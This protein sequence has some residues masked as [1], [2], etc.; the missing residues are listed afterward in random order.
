QIAMHWVGPDVFRRYS[1][2][3]SIV[4]PRFGPAQRRM[5]SAAMI[6]IHQNCPHP[7][8]ALE[9]LDFCYRRFIE[10]NA[11]YPFGV[12]EEDRQVLRPL[13][14]IHR[15]LRE[16]LEGAS[17]PLQEGVPQRT[18][19]IENEI[20]D[21]FRLFI[22]RKQRVDRLNVHWDRWGDRVATEGEAET[23]FIIPGETG[24]MPRER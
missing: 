13:P 21:W 15:L 7:D 1:F 5:V 24:G 10:N 3:T 11:E 16:S 4:I 22:D 12:H 18:W 19:A 6:V 8:V 9:F 23:S 20:F 14:E 2:P 17:E